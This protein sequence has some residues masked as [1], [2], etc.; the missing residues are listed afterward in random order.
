MNAAKKD[1]MPPM[2]GA[3]KRMIMT[4]AAEPGI[5]EACTHEPCATK[6]MLAQIKARNLTDINVTGQALVQTNAMWPY[7]PDLLAKPVPRYTSY[8]TAVDF[9]DGI[10]SAEYERALADMEAGTSLSLYVHIPYCE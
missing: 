7:Y 9:H 3:R 8:P 2:T 10:G 1:A 6:R 5:H 4:D